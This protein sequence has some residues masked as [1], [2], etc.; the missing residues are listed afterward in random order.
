MS[1]ALGWDKVDPGLDPKAF[2]LQTVRARLAKR[3]DP[4]KDLLNVRPDV[5]AAVAKLAALLGR[6]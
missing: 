4:T 2:T 1:T 3:G 5:S 6:G